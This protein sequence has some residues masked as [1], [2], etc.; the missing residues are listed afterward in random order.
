MSR[1]WPFESKTEGIETL[2][3]PEDFIARLGSEGTE[4]VV[5]RIG[6]NDAMLVLVDGDGRWERWVFHSLDE[7]VRAANTLGVPVH[8]GEYPEA[9]RVRMG[10]YQPS[11]EH[12]AAAAYPEQGR[13]GPVTGYPENRPRRPEVAAK[14]RTEASPPE[15]EA[16][17]ES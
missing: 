2:R 5:M 12:Y 6:L 15:P 7:A 11:A 13:V 9:T 14:E 1:A 3:T 17:D 10:K 8:E 4:A 16:E